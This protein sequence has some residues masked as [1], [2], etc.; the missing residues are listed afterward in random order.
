MSRQCNVLRYS[1]VEPHFPSLRGLEKQ[2]EEGPL[3]TLATP[4]SQDTMELTWM[5]FGSGVPGDENS[6]FI[7]SLM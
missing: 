2:H 1:S 3:D 5:A 7:F 4:D 6:Y